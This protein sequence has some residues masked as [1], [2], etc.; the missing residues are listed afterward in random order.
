MDKVE[1]AKAAA[2]REAQKA[3]DEKKRVEEEK[4]ECTILQLGA[5]VIAA[6]TGE[7]LIEQIN[8]LVGW[9]LRTPL[10]LIE[11]QSI[12]YEL[13]PGRHYSKIL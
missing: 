9:P 12:R 6:M 2:S 13:G 7:K 1:A 10:F 4:L 5:T 11:Q 8:K 3:R